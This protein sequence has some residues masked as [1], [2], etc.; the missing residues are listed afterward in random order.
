L[1][2][3]TVLHKIG[4]HLQAIV[5]ADQDLNRIAKTQGPTVRFSVTLVCRIKSMGASGI[6][7]APQS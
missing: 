1:A 4:Y 3:I 6:V 2:E 7:T 5:D